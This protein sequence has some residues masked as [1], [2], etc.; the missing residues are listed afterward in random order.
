[1]KEYLKQ[2]EIIEDSLVD[3]VDGEKLMGYTS[4]IAKWVRISGTQEEVDSLLYCEKVM[5]EIGYN[6]KLTYHDAFISV[7]VESHVEML[8]PKQM[9]F[10]SLTHCFT[11]STAE[12]G[13]EGFAVEADCPNIRGLIVM[14][15]GLPNA[16]Q[17]RDMQQMGAAAV[18]YVQDNHL[19][20]SP[21]SSLWGAPQRKQRSC[22]RKYQ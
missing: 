6:T 17:V 9:S 11:K 13:M 12:N 7:P 15:D 3:S 10:K 1:M 8:S 16:D 5:Q 18:I 20:N 2:L 22:Y 21:V 4:D 19:H 14:I